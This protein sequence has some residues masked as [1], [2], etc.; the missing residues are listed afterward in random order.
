MPVLSGLL[1]GRRWACPALCP[2]LF[3]F[4]GLPGLLPVW[5]VDPL[6]MSPSPPGLLGTPPGVPPTERAGTRLLSPVPLP[7]PEVSARVPP[8]ELCSTSRL[9]YWV[10]PSPVR[11]VCLPLTLP[12]PGLGLPGHAGTWSPLPVLLR[13][14]EVST[15]APLGTLWGKS[16]PGLS[17]AGLAAVMSRS[18]SLTA[19][20]LWFSCRPPLSGS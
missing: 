6:L 4:Y 16:V 5:A 9:S 11:A 18:L 10:W 3:W 15:P 20:F 12:C 1:R 7:L 13:P 2:A 14:P 17:L 19:F 8:F